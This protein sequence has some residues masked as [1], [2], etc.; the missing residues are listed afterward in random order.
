MFLQLQMDIVQGHISLVGE[1][2][3]TLFKAGVLDQELPQLV[4]DGLWLLLHL[5]NRQTMR[6][7]GPII[8][9]VYF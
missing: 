1:V 2:I 3:P 8:T 6:I 7:T 4:L 5:P 9:L